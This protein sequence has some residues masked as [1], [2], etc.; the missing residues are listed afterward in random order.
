VL[1]R[2]PARIGLLLIFVWVTFLIFSKRTDLRGELAF[3]RFLYLDK[4]VETTEKGP[5]LDMAVQSAL[6]E[7]SLVASFAYQDP[8]ALADADDMIV[9]WTN[10]RT[11]SRSLRISCSTESAN[12]ARHAVIGAPSHYLA[13]LV[14]ART[15]MIIG[16]WDAAEAFLNRARQLVKHPDQVRMFNSPPVKESDIE[17]WL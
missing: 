7:A 10:N 1:P 16:E 15:Q 2:N 12:L 14:L 3:S 17:P 8:D 4:I 13:W 5:A 11:I 6:Q 9:R